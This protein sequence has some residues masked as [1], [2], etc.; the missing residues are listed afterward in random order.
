M[1]QGRTASSVALP[2]PAW[3]WEAGHLSAGRGDGLTQSLSALERVGLLL[4][5]IFGVVILDLS[6]GTSGVTLLVYHSSVCKLGTIVIPFLVARRVL[7]TVEES[8]SPGSQCCIS[9][10]R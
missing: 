6:I 2:L 9:T 3:R 10:M 8:R 1:L 7:T 4:C 5:S